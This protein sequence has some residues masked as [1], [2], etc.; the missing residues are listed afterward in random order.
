MNISQVSLRLATIKGPSKMWSLTTLSCL[1]RRF[2]EF[3]STSNWH[4]N[5]RPRVT[6]PAKDFHIQHVHLHDLPPRQLMQQSVCIIKDGWILVF[7]VQDR[8]ETVCV[9]LCGW[10]VC[11]CQCCW[12][13]D[14]WWQWGYVWAGV[15]YWQQPLVHFIDAILNAQRCCDG[16]L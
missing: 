1:Q 10:A 14:S 9:T 7:T 8:W 13:S 12:S 5:H 3:G 6:T 15:C 16:I 2:R 4:H 11:W